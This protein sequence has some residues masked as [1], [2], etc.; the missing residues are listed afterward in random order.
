MPYYRRNLYILCTTIFLA[1]VSW[2]QVIPFLPLY[3]REMGTNSDDLIRWS[4]I[5]FALPAVS[6]V[7]AQPL[8]GKMGDKYGRKPMI[9]RAG[10]FLAAIYFGMSMCQT[11]LQL[12]IL[13]FLN[14]ALTGFI[15]G[16]MI[17]IATNT[18]EQHVTKYVARSQSASAAG[19]I[20]GPAIGGFLASLVGYKG[21]MIVS[22][23]AVAL[24]TIAVLAFVKEP[25]KNSTDDKTSIIQDF[26]M[27]IQS[28]IIGSVMF[29]ALASV[30]FGA[31]ITPILTL[32]LNKMNGYTPELFSG[33]IFALPALAFVLSANIW[34]IFGEKYGFD[35]C[36]KIGFLFG[37][38]GSLGLSLVGNIWVFGTIF[39]V[40]GIFLAAFGPSS[41]G[42][43][44][45]SV[46]ENF[47]GR[48]YGMQSASAMLGALFAPLISTKIASFWGIKS[49]FIFVAISF[50]VSFL[51]FSFIVRKWPRKKIA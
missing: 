17:L 44:C 28:P 40:S 19:L 25:N 47:R 21:T 34:A 31:S 12:A 51:I 10:I 9:I 1:A 30:L 41:A 37:S 23:I 11:P 7:L 38:I 48:A 18:P 35:K 4:G 29:T 36:I 15:P 39:F 14:G 5:I 22:G 3:L 2:N 46:D 16:S 26:S 8:W 50:I 24:C 13:R 43:M 49:V 33:I 6:S 32:H 27:A 20:I 45:T 42:I